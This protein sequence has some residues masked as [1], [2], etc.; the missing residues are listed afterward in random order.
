MHHWVFHRGGGG[1]VTPCLASLEVPLRSLVHTPPAVAAGGGGAG[2][3]AADN[4]AGGVLGCGTAA[5]AR[6]GL[7]PLVVFAP[8]PVGVPTAAAAALDVAGGGGEGG[9]VR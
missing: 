9:T 8:Y 2:G 6:K 4:V 1:G 5:A 3:G 7:H